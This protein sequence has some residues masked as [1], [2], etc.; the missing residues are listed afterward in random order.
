MIGSFRK[1]PRDSSS[2][3][4]CISNSN[5]S[6]WLFPS[7]EAIVGRA[8][9]T[10]EASNTQLHCLLKSSTFLS[11]LPDTSHA[12]IQPRQVPVFCAGGAVAFCSSPSF[13]VTVGGTASW[14]VVCW[15]LVKWGWYTVST[16]IRVTAA[17]FL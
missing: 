1:C 3:L 17:V 6:L 16:Q 13:L 11:V 10:S 7:L 9:N 14:G 15:V 8:R 5:L 4:N 2:S 12:G